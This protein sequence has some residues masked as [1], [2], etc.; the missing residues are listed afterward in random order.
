[1]SLILR[2]FARASRELATGME[3]AEGME[4][5]RKEERKKERKTLFF[6]KASFRLSLRLR[7]SLSHS[8]AR[9]TRASIRHAVNAKRVE[10]DLIFITITRTKEEYFTREKESKILE[11]DCVTLMFRCARRSQLSTAPVWDGRECFLGLQPSA[12]SWYQRVSVYRYSTIPRW[13]V[14]R[15]CNIHM[16]ALSHV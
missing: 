13:N 3:G 14:C 10:S 4:G 2:L 7:L 15:C 1:M 5:G 8:R 9:S 16:Y 12:H 11:I 6:L